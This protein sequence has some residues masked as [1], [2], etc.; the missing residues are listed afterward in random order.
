MSQELFVN[1]VNADGTIGYEIPIDS[2]L[3]ARAARGDK[4]TRDELNSLRLKKQNALAHFGVAEGVDAEK[5]ESAGWGVIFPAGLPE[6]TR[7]AIQ[8]ALKPL[9]EHRKTQAGECY[10]EYLGSERGLQ[11]GES[12]AEFLKR[13][14]RGPG[15]ARPV[16]DDGT[17]GVPYYLLIAGSP[18]SI[19]FPFQYQLDVQYAVGRIYFD[20]LEEYYQ[21]ASSV[22]EAET[23]GL[24][25]SRRA[26]FF[27]VANA[28][29]RA[30][31]MSSKRLILPLSQAVETK[32]GASGW[33]VR[34]LVRFLSSL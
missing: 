6:K 22:V 34:L 33:G 23:R 24:Q 5:L 14:G 2:Q 30:T 3:I 11:N 25:R 27:G 32:L 31:E 28:D 13:Y 19:P 16:E 18:E 26:A 12:K 17:P 8:E 9:L 1:G 10:Q 4:L 7:D 15:P 21:Y 20:K 29:D